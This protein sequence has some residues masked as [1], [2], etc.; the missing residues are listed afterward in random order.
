MLRYSKVFDKLLVAQFAEQMAMSLGNFLFMLF[1]ARLLGPADFGIVAVFWTI[2]QL[3]SVL[4]FAL[5][6]LPISSSKDSAV[7]RA[8]VV[9]H[10]WVLY[11]PIVG[12]FAFL[13]PLIFYALAGAT[14][15]YGFRDG[16]ILILWGAGQ[17][18]LD[19][20][21]W[22]VIRYGDHRLVLKATIARWI[23]FFALAGP[24]ALTGGE[25]AYH[26]YMGLNIV[27]IGLWLA[28]V[29]VGMPR[30]VAVLG[31]KRRI[32]RTLLRLSWPILANGLANIGLNY[33][34]VLIFMHIFTLDA[35]G[36]FQ[37][38][39]SIANVFG[40]PAQFID[41]HFT[42]QMAREGKAIS[43]SFRYYGAVL[44]GLTASLVIGY[45]TKDV[46]ANHLLN[47][48]YTVYAFMFPVLFFGATTQLVVRPVF[49][50]LRLSGATEILYWNTALLCLTIVPLVIV[51]ALV[52]SQ[53]GVIVFFALAPLSLLLLD[54]WRK[55]GRAP[56]K[57]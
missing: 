54:A 51:A 36:A 27:C 49:S 50:A 22:L 48:D 6:L 3:P 31:A 52:E 41:N 13:S 55:I 21:R 56:A 32:S 19:L 25:L 26:G 20:N 12:G 28:V 42:A 35:L 37:A 44:V 1:G 7:S 16:A 18:A 40:M 53:M 34:V 43:L 33:L 47:A 11:F 4:F 38:Y 5:I 17:S 8:E 10:A 2:I 39:R 30:E 14:L 57:W 45:L 46:V 23:V 24:L 15:S 9:G 29:L